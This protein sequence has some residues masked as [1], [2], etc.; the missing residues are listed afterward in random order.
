[1][2]SDKS[3]NVSTPPTISSLLFL[4][5]AV[6]TLMG[7]VV[8]SLLIILTCLPVILFFVLKVFPRIQPFSQQVERKISKHFDPR[9]S[10]FVNPVILSAAALN[11]VIFQSLSTAKAPSTMLSR[12]IS[13]QF[14]GF[15]FFL[16]SFIL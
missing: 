9:A 1:M 2:I 6:L 11:Q 14:E 7:I 15:Y 12:I 4:K 3:L 5:I 10:S 8:P 13:D 16:L